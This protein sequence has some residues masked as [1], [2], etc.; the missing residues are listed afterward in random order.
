MDAP[1]GTAD[2]GRSGGGVSDWARAIAALRDSESFWTWFESHPLY[3]DG[4]EVLTK[5]PEVA[6]EY[7]EFLAGRCPDCWAEARDG[8]VDG[9]S[10][11]G[12]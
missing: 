9:C 8:H 3:E 6:A 11:E 5:F 7:L 4:A 1:T 10:M 2:S 12:S